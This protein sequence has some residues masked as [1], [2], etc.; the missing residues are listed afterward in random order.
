ML[1]I[2]HDPRTM[3]IVFSVAI[4]I[5]LGYLYYRLVGCSSG[6]CPI[7]SNKY[8]SMIYGGVIGM[9]FALDR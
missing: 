9:L 7:T 4:G 2:I 1:E 6:A 5:F 8:T 3:K